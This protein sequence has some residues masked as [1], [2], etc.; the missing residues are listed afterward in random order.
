MK[1]VVL[2]SLSMHTDE[3]KFIKSS[4]PCLSHSIL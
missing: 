1:I 3:E 4:L 2:S